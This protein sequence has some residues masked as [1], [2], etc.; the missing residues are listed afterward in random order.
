MRGVTIWRRPPGH[1]AHA[2]RISDNLFRGRP[3]APILCPGIPK[4]FR[5]QGGKYSGRVQCTALSMHFPQRSLRSHTILALSLYKGD[6]AR[7]NA[8]S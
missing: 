2:D 8:S 4:L 7:A 1:R 6:N 5:S 3:S